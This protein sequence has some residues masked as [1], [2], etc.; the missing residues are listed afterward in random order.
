MAKPKI[1]PG[2][3]PTERMG[4]I[5]RLLSMGVPLAAATALASNQASAAEPENLSL[6]PV[7]GKP[8]QFLLPEGVNANPFATPSP[9]EQR[10][11]PID[12]LP[13]AAMTNRRSMLDYDIE[14]ERGRQSATKAQVEAGV[15]PDVAELRATK[16][17][18]W[19]RPTI[20]AEAMR[21]ISPGYEG[22]APVSP[23]A[24]LRQHLTNQAIG[25]MMEGKPT[26]DPQNAYQLAV[27]SVM[28]FA[29][30]QDAPRDENSSV[31]ETSWDST[32]EVSRQALQDTLEMIAQHAPEGEFSDKSGIT[33]AE[34]EMLNQAHGNHANFMYPDRLRQNFLA[35]RQHELLTAGMQGHEPSSGMSMALRAVGAPFDAD[36]MAMH[37]QD[38]AAL[39]GSMDPQAATAKQAMY[40]W[41]RS[42]PNPNALGYDSYR[43]EQTNGSKYGKYSTTTTTGL[44]GGLGEDASRLYGAATQYMQPMSSDT[45]QSQPARQF[46]S[47]IRRDTKRPVPIIRPGLTP[48]ETD[49]FGKIAKDYG[50]KSDAWLTAKMAPTLGGYPT[51]FA[52]T[53]LNT[54]RYLAEP[55]TAIST[56][57]G[58]TFGGVGG[59][60]SGK[61]LIGK[62]AKSAQGVSVPAVKNVGDESLENGLSDAAL[63]SA[64]GRAASDFVLKPQS[65]NPL[66]EDE[67]GN[68]VDPLDTNRH[69]ATVDRNW[70]TTVR[71]LEG[72]ANRYGRKRYG[73]GR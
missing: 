67:N 24:F 18:E 27:R 70:D 9:D 68:Q 54:P 64:F 59:L 45:F 40:W 13:D 25:L 16:I 46:L 41:N 1:R 62:L 6:Q 39:H 36:T 61:T 26:F 53:V 55:V 8:G 2:D 65:E 31:V 63:G 69:R 35:Q 32:P 30:N 10:Q 52:D 58:A 19:A 56:A 4:R 7:E 11:I 33:E 34:L 42:K 43:D 71:T 48:Q 47:E 38:M 37:K 60:R 22:D 14:G 73:F 57:L 20:S 21:S 51:G 5:R 72:A 50:T 23:D 3:M 12:N 66:A 28:G 17:M 15:D 49:E 29:G 44:I